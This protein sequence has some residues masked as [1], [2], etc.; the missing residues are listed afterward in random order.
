[1]DIESAQLIVE[2]IGEVSKAI[3]SM[4]I[5]IIT[6]MAIAVIWWICNK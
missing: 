1:M 5:L 2:A 4:G 6:I 3:Y